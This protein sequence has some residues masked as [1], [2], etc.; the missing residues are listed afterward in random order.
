MNFWKKLFSI[1]TYKSESLTSAPFKP[2]RGLNEQQL[3]EKELENLVQPLIKKATRI[4]VCKPSTPPEH[5]QLV[6]HFGGQPYFEEGEEWPISMKGKSMDFIFQLFNEEGLVLPKEIKLIQF[7]YDWEEFPW[8]TENDG[9]RVKIYEELNPAQIKTIEKPTNLDVSHYCEIQFE[10]I[11]SL[12]A[13][14]G[15]DCYS[16]DASNLSNV[17]NEDKPW[18][19]YDKVVQKLTGHDGFQSQLGG[20]PTW[21]QGES[22][23]KNKNGDSMPLLFQ[24]D[25]EDN[26]GIMWGDCGIVYVFY[27]RDS[28]Q[29]EFILQCH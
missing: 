27:D 12:P 25:S 23:P 18:D 1:P 17:L 20:Y 14:E 19:S 4:N 3:L 2:A 29:L 13:W 5:S 7:F 21:I 24:I 11:V 15:L 10:N 28:K 16:S 9:W 6:S 22:T 26:A 8:E